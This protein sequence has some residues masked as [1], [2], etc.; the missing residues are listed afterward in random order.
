MNRSLQVSQS[1]LIRV[2][3]VPFWLWCRDL[4]LTAIAWIAIVQSMRQGIYLLYDYFAPPFFQFTH[5]SAPRFVDIWNP[6]SLFLFIAAGFVLWL[7]FWAFVNTRRFRKVQAAAQPPPL[8]IGDHAKHLGLKQE[9]IEQWRTYRI[10]VVH[11]DSDSQISSVLRYDLAS[12]K[13]ET[14]GKA[15]FVRHVG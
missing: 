14:T 3:R 12:T 6:L 10:A 9:E 13:S 4:L 2:K 7:V 5:A 11:F 1:P 15:E 8:E